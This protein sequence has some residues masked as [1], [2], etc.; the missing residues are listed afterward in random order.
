MFDFFFTLAD[1]NTI[2]FPGLDWTTA[3]THPE[4][5]QAIALDL[6]YT[7]IGFFL[8]DKEPLPK[9]NEIHPIRAKQ[10]KESVHKLDIPASS[11]LKMVIYNLLIEGDIGTDVIASRCGVPIMDIVDQADPILKNVDLDLIGKI[12]KQFGLTMMIVDENAKIGEDKMEDTKMNNNS[13]NTLLRMS[14]PN[15]GFE[16]SRFKP[17]QTMEKYAKAF[18]AVGARLSVDELMEKMGLQYKGKVLNFLKKWPAF[19]KEVGTET[20]EMIKDPN[21]NVTKRAPKE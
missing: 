4:G 10:M 1:D 17:N 12:L 13:L 2:H 20:Y 15:T 18:G 14:S 5:A 6:F 9:G 7:E 19:F 21:A 16:A 3:A 8:E 11:K